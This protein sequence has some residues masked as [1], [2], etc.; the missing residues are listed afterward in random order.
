MVII[1]SIRDRK[2]GTYEK[3]VYGINLA[4]FLRDL[5]I[6]AGQ[7]GSLLGSYPDDFEVCC[8][9]TFSPEGGVIELNP[10]PALLG[11]VRDLLEAMENAE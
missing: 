4:T 6:A 10:Q 3:P 8:L 9:G 2:V 1:Y 11:T 7:P 5:A